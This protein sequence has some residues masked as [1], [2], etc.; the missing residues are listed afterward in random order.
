MT[1]HTILFVD[2][3]ENVLKALVRL[4]RN[5]DHSLLTA[6]SPRDGL[7][8][9]SENLV[10]LVVADHRMPEMTGV[11][12][13]QCVEEKSPD[14]VR[15]MLTG[16]ADLEVA[17]EAINQGEIY[18]FIRKPWDED[19]MKT[20]VTQALERYELLTEN[21]RMARIIKRQNEILT[22]HKEEL[23]GKVIQLTRTMI[24]IE[25]EFKRLEQILEE[26][27][28]SIT[29]VSSPLSEMK[30]AAAAG[31]SGDAHQRR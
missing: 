24:N 27:L 23:K 5:Q 1:K 2:D 16:H 11:E 15:I 26:G 3:E 21:K 30:A 10:S 19:E 25:Q 28:T 29:T 12:F 8:K 6:T 7:K 9:I 4:F 14:T 22:R 13:L 20:T 31:H 17:V 18:R